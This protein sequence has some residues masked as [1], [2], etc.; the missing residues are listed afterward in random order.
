MVGYLGNLL[1]TL[2]HDS[3]L[4]KSVLKFFGTISQTS[5][6][7]FEPFLN[8]VFDLSVNYIQKEIDIHFDD[9][10]TF[11]QKSSNYKSIDLDLKIFGGKKVLSL[12]H[13]LMEIKITS[14]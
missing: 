14:C 1:S 3:I 9:K 8:D 6:K 11:T 7:L 2:E 4:I 13:S 12:N 10:E 5:T